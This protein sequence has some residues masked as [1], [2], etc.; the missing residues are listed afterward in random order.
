MLALALALMVGHPLDGGAHERE[1]HLTLLGHRWWRVAALLGWHCQVGIGG[2]AVEDG[3]GGDGQQPWQWWVCRS[4]V[5]VA[6]AQH[7]H[8]SV[9]GAEGERQGCCGVGR[10]AEG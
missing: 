5:E 2:V 1:T 4:V 7:P 3:G 10:A 6:A 9:V 8:R